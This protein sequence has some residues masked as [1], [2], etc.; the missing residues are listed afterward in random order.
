MVIN[1][2]VMVKIIV[3]VV[4]KEILERFVEMEFRIGISILV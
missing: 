4:T 2:E 1:I 3:I